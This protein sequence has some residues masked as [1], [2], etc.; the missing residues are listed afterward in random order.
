[1]LRRNCIV[2]SAI[3]LGMTIYIGQFN[4]SFAKDKIEP[5]QLVAEHLKALGIPEALQQ[6]KTRLMIGVATM[7]YILGGSGQLAGK[8]NWASEK[9]KMGLVIQFG[10]RDY[11][12][13]HFAYDGKDVMVNYIQTGGQRSPLGNFL[14]NYDGVMKNGLF[15]GVLY[16]GWP[17]LDIKESK[18]KMKVKTKTVDDKE[19]YEVEYM[20]RKSM[21]D[22]K[23]KLYFDP[24]TYRHVM[25]EYRLRKV[26]MGQS[27]SRGS[28]S[29][30]NYLLTEKF[31]DFK[32]VD[33]ITLPHKY[34][35]TYELQGRS[36]LT[37][38][39]TFDAEK[40]GH[41]GTIDPRFY[42]AQK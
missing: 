8:A 22:V 15:G 28:E 4:N 42:E 3:L 34:S 40:I 36:S 9:G 12:G 30:T 7:K 27:V 2:V 41:N 20:P 23:V 6:I 26:S 13:E 35:L 37:V 24:E 10:A 33:G 32:P 21:E 31:E 39:Y 5:E 11:P 29:T 17:L 38:L 18:P 25:T 14:L 16:V 1:M 19:L